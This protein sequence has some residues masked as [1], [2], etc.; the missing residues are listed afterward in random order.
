MEG[1]GKTQP[2]RR[3]WGA[4]EKRL[5]HL[6]LAATS[7]PAKPRPTGRW[8]RSW[9]TWM[10]LKKRPKRRTRPCGRSWRR[11]GHEDRRVP[12]SQRLEG[13]PHCRCVRFYT[14][15]PRGLDLSK[16][17][18]KIPFFP[19][20]RIPLKGIHVSE[21]VPKDPWPNSGA[22]TYVENGDLMVAKITEEPSLENGKQAIVN[23]ATRFRICHY[24]G[25]PNA[26]EGW[27]IGYT[28]PVLLSLA[29]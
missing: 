15:K 27:R 18:D 23:I 16:N 29:S 5:Q 4:E 19:M 22:G 3:S 26:W 10:R 7:T 6:S 1:R 21:F 14:V 24:R 12:V 25:D 13:L 28:V 11:S 2:N 9:R 17:G 20:N 8:R